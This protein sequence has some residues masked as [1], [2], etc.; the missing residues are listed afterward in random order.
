MPSGSKPG[1][2][3]GG[4]KR[5][6]ANTSSQELRQALLDAACSLPN[7]IAEILANEETVDSI[8]IGFLTVLLPYLY[9]K[10]ATID[11]DG[12]MSCEDVAG[13]MGQLSLRFRDAMMSAGIDHQVIAEVL[14]QVQPRPQPYGLLQ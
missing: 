14:D 13:M 8:K 3:R 12:Y 10:L 6:T 4:R 2:H 9:P 7:T 5:G 11:L 1:E